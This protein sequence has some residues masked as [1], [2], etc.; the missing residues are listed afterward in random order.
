[1]DFIDVIKALG[2]KVSRM[3]DSIQTE[4]AT[5]M[6]FVMPFISALGY[7]VFNPHE[8]VPEFVADLG[9]KKG[10][11]V[12]YCILKD[13]SPIMIIECKHWKEDLNV[14]NSQ[15][16][17]YFHV[18]TTRFGILT[19]GIIYKF[20]T[21]LVESNKMDDKPFWEF[22]ITDISDANVFELK[23]YQ[24]N[25]FNVDTILSSA[26]ELKFAREIKKILLEE[27]NNPSEAFV[28]HFARQI[29]TGPMIA[30]VL[31]QFTGV[32][33]R[34]LNQFI[35][36]MI[37][38]RLKSALASEQDRERVDI[39]ARVEED[40]TVTP[41]KEPESKIVT[42]EIEKEAFFIVRSILR[43]KVDSSRITHRDTQSYF[44]ILLD[45]NNRKPICRLYLEGN[46]K[47][48][49]YFDENRKEVK[50]EITNLDDIYKYSDQLE[51]TALSYD[52]K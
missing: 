26:T 51:A 21:D 19:N 40:V 31:E 33:K 18:T 1:M 46:K 30:K 44:G 41:V 14:H 17:R 25:S 42:H 2:E 49:V 38:D 20:Y 23:K 7:D 28:K 4:E 52:S 35:T 29:H 6:A 10:E 12:D 39:A 27:F 32:V 36:D 34:S 43:T 48:I 11:K 3:K 8:V 47:F 15:L 16:H 50:N 45:N 24:R 37:S 9:I 13:D 5:K 22:N